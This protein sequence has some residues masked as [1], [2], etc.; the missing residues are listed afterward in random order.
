M[1]KRVN[2]WQDA[3]GSGTAKVDFG[4]GVVADVPI[5]GAAR[6]VGAETN[7]SAILGREL[8]DRGN[9]TVAL[10][11][12]ADGITTR[13]TYA[14]RLSTDA[15]GLGL[16]SGNAGK[17][18]VYDN[19]GQI[20]QVQTALEAG[21]QL[22]FRRRNAGVWSAWESPFKTLASSI[23]TTNGNVTSVTSKVTALEATR[24]AL[25]ALSRSA[26]TEYTNA[27]PIAITQRQPFRT[28]GQCTSFKICF[29]NYDER[30]NTAYTGQVAVNGVWMGEAQLGTDGKPN[31]QF[32]GTPVQVSG[33]LTGTAD[34]TMFSTAIIQ[35][36]TFAIDPAKTYIVS[37]GITADGTVLHRTQG[38]SWFTS[39]PLNADDPVISITLTSTKFSILETWVEVNTRSPRVAWVGDSHAAAGA[40]DL[41]VFEAPVNLYCFANGA[42]PV[43]SGW[44][45][46]R[47]LELT[48]GNDTRWLKHSQAAAGADAWVLAIGQNSIYNDS[49]DLA[50]LKSQLATVVGIGKNIFGPNMYLATIL[51]RN[52]AGQEAQNSVRLAYNDWLRSLPHGA[53]NCYDIA[54]KVTTTSDALDSRYIVADNIHMNTA[55]NAKQTHA[56]VH[57]LG[58]R[59]V[60]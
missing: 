27:G 30:T 37:Y 39:S 34:G 17:L 36:T 22:Y 6:I 47:T 35:S 11:T 26:G 3:Y 43:N 24:K 16:P 13:G 29:R 38:Q 7:I 20:I 60:A 42:V 15:T 10:Y 40:A 19:N 8:P 23:A 31:G 14:V 59:V 58:S 49:L 33:A 51:P 32:K 4:D 55:G 28:G 53:L 21:W 54:E 45:G 9:A 57:A 5:A 50:T 56:I 18:D 41:A 46:A 2:T 12:N 25:V 44:G 52:V 1:V 48:N